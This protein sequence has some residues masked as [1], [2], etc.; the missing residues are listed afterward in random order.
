[1][2]DL[3]RSPSAWRALVDQLDTN[4]LRLL[5][6]IEDELDGTGLTEFEQLTGELIRH[7]PHLAATIRVVAGHVIDQRPMLRG[8]C[9]TPE[10]GALAPGCF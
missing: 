10:R 5:H 8:R 6:T 2:I 4:Q 3:S 7:L 9:C 1:M